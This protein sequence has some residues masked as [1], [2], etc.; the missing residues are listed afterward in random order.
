MA[1]Q[2][3]Q[4]GGAA[5]STAAFTKAKMAPRKAAAVKIPDQPRSR[6]VAL[7]VHVGS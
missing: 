4:A 5:R 6:S 1:S 3:A 2:R 7:G